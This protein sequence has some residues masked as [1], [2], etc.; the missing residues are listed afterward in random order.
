MRVS[1]RI[2]PQRRATASTTFGWRSRWA[3]TMQVRPALRIAQNTLSSV[4][5]RHLVRV[6]K[7][8]AKHAVNLCGYHGC[9]PL[10]TPLYTTTIAA[11][12]FMRCPTF[13]ISYAVQCQGTLQVRS[14]SV[15]QMP[16]TFAG[17]LL[18]SVHCLSA[19]IPATLSIADLDYLFFHEHI[20]TVLNVSCTRP[21]FRM[22]V[23]GS[24]LLTRC[25]HHAQS[26]LLSDGRAV[27][28][29]PGADACFCLHPLAAAGGQGLPPLGGGFPQHL[30]ARAASRA[31]GRGPAPHG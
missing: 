28:T 19:L 3:G 13:R 10:Q 27:D 5:V 22:L 8:K 31:H 7:T 2:P 1:A 23:Y 21:R 24:P 29:T 25:E 16:A 17:Q 30:L 18:S 6:H 15:C 12:T 4:S 9:A 14:C 26:R 11:Y 20:D